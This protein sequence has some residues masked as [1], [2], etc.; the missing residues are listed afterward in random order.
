V[1]YSLRFLNPVSIGLG[2][3]W[4]ILPILQLKSSDFNPFCSVV[5][6]RVAFGVSDSILDSAPYSPLVGLGQA[7]GCLG[8]LG[9]FSAV[10]TARNR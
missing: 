9:A 10:A 5:F 1:I 6:I 8:A 2:L 4:G 3:I 7:V